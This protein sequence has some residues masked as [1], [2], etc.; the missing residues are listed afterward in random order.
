MG[1]H[2][3]E[4]V[5]SHQ[6]RHSGSGS[7]KARSIL[8]QCLPAEWSSEQARIRATFSLTVHVWTSSVQQSLGDKRLAKNQTLTYING[9]AREEPMREVRDISPHDT[10]A[11]PATAYSPSKTSP[12][13][14]SDTQSKLPQWV[15]NDRKVSRSS[16]QSTSGSQ[17]THRCP[18]G[19][20]GLPADLALLLCAGWRCAGPPLLWLLQGVSGGEQ[21]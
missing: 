11:V 8:Q 12:A 16:Q 21:H 5:H 20:T 17:P 19:E 13:A 14:F 3:L 2:N 1:A 4:H 6:S 15:E 9:Y 10:S 18:G 7:K